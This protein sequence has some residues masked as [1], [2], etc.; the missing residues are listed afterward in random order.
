[1]T[2]FCGATELPDTETSYDIARKNR[3]TVEGEGV[4]KRAVWKFAGW[5]LIM[6]SLVF[7]T[8]RES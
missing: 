1:M 3:E 2:V 7:E 8:R 5:P 4:A 6:Y